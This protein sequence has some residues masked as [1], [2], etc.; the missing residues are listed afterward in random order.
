MKFYIHITQC[1]INE[2]GKRQKRVKGFGMLEEK[3]YDFKQAFQVGCIEKV[4]FELEVSKL[5]CCV[6]IQRRSVLSREN[7]KCKDSQ[8]VQCLECVKI[9]QG[10]R[11]TAAEG[12]QKRRGQITQGFMP[13]TFHLLPQIHSFLFAI[14]K[15]FAL[16]LASEQ[17]TMYT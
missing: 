15:S 12:T 10:A 5:V 9:Y 2:M 16:L 7:S 4:I 17:H 1:V 13:N 8:V 6:D 14:R 3:F 11:V